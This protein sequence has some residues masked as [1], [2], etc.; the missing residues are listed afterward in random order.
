MKKLGLFL[1]FLITLVWGCGYGMHYTKSISI[2]PVPSMVTALNVMDVQ[3]AQVATRHGVVGSGKTEFIKNIFINELLQTKRF[4]ITNDAEYALYV[5]IDD[6]RAGYRKYIALSSKIVNT[7]TNEIV[8]N[9]SISGLSKKYIDEVIKN[10]V[11]EMV[12]EMTK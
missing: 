8:W 7:K 6:Y 3:D 1:I 9:S 2:N 10:T 5:K 11:K 4:K 12:R